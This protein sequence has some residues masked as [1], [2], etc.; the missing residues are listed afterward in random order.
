MRRHLISDYRVPDTAVVDLPNGLV[1]EDRRPPPL[2]ARLLP[3]PARG[4]FMLAMGR[5]VPYKGW[6][7]LLDA[8]TILQC[9]G[10]AVPHLLLAAVTDDRHLNPYQQHLADRIRSHGLPVTLCP[11]FDPAVRG[12]L[13]HPALA[14]V[15]VASRA[16]PF[17][18]IPLEAFLA[19]G[20]VVSTTA[21]GLA[22]LV[23]DD[24][25]YAARPGD[26]A[27]LADAIARALAASP[28]ERER[29]REAGRRLAFGRYDYDHT[30]H[31]MLARLAPWAVRSP[32][33]Q[34]T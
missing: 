19:G 15:I 4:G 28:A 24:T 2:D 32:V 12:L 25:G 34:S 20:T 5:A 27:S 10:V 21:G 13:A 11:R 23:T 8:L 14:A 16:E 33:R 30:V 17:G 7:D 18:R 29:R 6:D 26:A 1:A 22:E 9:R 3:A 31:D